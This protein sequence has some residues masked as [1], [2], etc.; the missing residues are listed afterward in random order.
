VLRGVFNL[1]KYKCRACGYVYD[2]QR[3]EP[4]SDTPAGTDFEELDNKWICPKCK[5]GK[6]RFQKYI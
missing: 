3:G 4:K 5:A 1:A 6:N 2:P